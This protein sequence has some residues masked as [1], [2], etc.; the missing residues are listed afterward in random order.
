M[1]GADIYCSIVNGISR[2]AVFSQASTTA[3]SRLL[4]SSSDWEYA[5]WQPAISAITDQNPSVGNTGPVEQAYR[6]FCIRG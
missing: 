5:S 2:V 4:I 3:C 6:G 1:S